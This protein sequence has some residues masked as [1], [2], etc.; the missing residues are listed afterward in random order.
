MVFATI[1]KEILTK[2]KKMLKRV[3]NV[4]FSYKKVKKDITGCV[5]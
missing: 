4:R 1:K 5:L 3:K 2:R